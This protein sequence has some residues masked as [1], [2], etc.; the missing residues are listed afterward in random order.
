MTGLDRRVP[1]EGVT[2]FRDLGGYDMV[3][4]RRTRTGLVFRA[5][6]LDAL[7]EADLRQYGKLGIRIAYDLRQASERDARPLSVP[8]VHLCVMTAVEQAGVVIADRTLLAMHDD[9]ERLLRDMYAALLEHSAP[10]FGLLITALADRTRLPAVFHCHGGKDRTG[11]AAAL[12]L[13]LLG[14]DRQSVLDDYE[15][16]SNF[17]TREQQDGSYRALIESGM[18]P[19]AAAAVLGTPRWAMAD[20]LAAL[21][22]RHGGVEAYV[23]GPGAVEPDV[24]ARLRQQLVA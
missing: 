4:G 10:V 2:N 24:V 8:S 11:V 20:A 16:T 18:A 12:L 23:I 21:D 9:G 3:D 5:D 17:R 14:V 6:G 7:T 13:E 15:L 22:R 19:A 1:F